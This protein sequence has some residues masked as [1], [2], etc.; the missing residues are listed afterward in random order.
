M[1]HT[2]YSL[3]AILFCVF[4]VA[5]VDAI[6]AEQRFPKPDF[7]TDY[8]FHPITAPAP[9][10]DMMQWVDVGALLL[11]LSLFLR[12]PCVPVTE[13]MLAALMRDARLPN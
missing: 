5:L 7:E 13:N 9:R 4:N 6:A 11:A 2:V 8:E 10:A 1:K 12:Q 3:L